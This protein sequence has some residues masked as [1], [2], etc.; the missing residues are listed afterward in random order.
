MILSKFLLNSES[1]AEG[2]VAEVAAPEESV[3]GEGDESTGSLWARW[4]ASDS[5][6]ARGRAEI[7]SDCGLKRVEGKRET[8]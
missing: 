2:G 4:S 6:K 3:G 7:E 1:S 8:K 5:S